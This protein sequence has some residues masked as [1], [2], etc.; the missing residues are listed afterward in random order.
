MYGRKAPSPMARD[1]AKL[2]EGEVVFLYKSYNSTRL[3]GKQRSLGVKCS[4]RR[5]SH[6][7]MRISG[8]VFITFH[9]HQNNKGIFKLQPRPSP[10]SSKLPIA[11]ISIS[12]NSSSATAQKSNNVSST[13]HTCCV[14][15][16]HQGSYLT[17]SLKMPHAVIN[18]M[19]V[20][21]ETCEHTC[22][23]KIAPKRTKM[24][25][26]A[27]GKPVYAGSCRECT[28]SYARGQEKMFLEHYN[29]DIADLRARLSMAKNQ[30]D[31]GRDTP[32]SD[33]S[34]TSQ[35]SERIFSLERKRDAEVTAVWANVVREWDGVKLAYGGKYKGGEEGRKIIKVDGKEWSPEL[36][37]LDQLRLPRPGTM[38]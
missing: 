29:S 1:K 4:C 12:S 2:R 8:R 22:P 11:T 21:F 18:P 33:A 30:L 38:A 14:R 16:D 7:R 5:L 17:H 20:Y 32:D 24:T 13:L 37:S 27:K 35:I 31:G 25:I 9:L 15:T 19:T 23:P 36:E 6:F 3:P 34:I 26:D 28:L 10:S